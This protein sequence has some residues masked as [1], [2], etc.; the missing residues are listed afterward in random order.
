MTIL[1]APSQRR[2][3]DIAR[4]ISARPE[5]AAGAFVV[6]AWGLLLVLAAADARRGGATPAG[7]AGMS[8]MTGMPGMAPTG[9]PGAWVGLSRA[10][11]ELPHW[12]LMT[13][14]MMGPVALA[15]I[16]H[17]AINSLRWR[18]RRAMAEFAVAYLA[19]WT[20]FGYLALTG[21]GLVSSFPGSARLA[22][23]LAVASGWEFSPLKRRCLLSCHR[24]LPLPLSGLPAE[25]GAVRFGLRHGLSCLGAC[26]CLML[27]MAA[28][29]EGNLVWTVV[30]GCVIAAERWARHPRRVSRLAGG[31]LAAAAM[32]ALALALG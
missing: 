6:V 32:G 19:V 8:R 15:G 9:S 20:A 10:V 18:R 23:A 7:M 13:I 5:I 26:W 31:G 3:V 30:L 22:V 29:P 11:A 21:A 28:A 4:L 25:Q 16:R 1:D 27:I 17:T 12:T 24:S 2:R 14:A